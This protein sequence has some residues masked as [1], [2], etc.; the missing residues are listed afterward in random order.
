MYEG[1]GTGILK[2]SDDAGTVM[3]TVI[4]VTTV[5]IIMITNVGCIYYTTNRNIYDNNDSNAPY[6]RVDTPGERVVHIDNE[7]FSHFAHLEIH[8]TDQ[9]KSKAK[10]IERKGRMSL[11]VMKLLLNNI[12]PGTVRH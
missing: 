4:I 6:V 5:M 3:I 1:E 11:T 9:L 7:R 2:T 12:L 10:H 8:I